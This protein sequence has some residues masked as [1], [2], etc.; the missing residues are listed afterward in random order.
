M[1]PL[2]SNIISLQQAH[3]N[4]D[5]E[6]R[7]FENR[8]GW[9]RQWGSC[10]PVKSTMAHDGPL[11]SDGLFETFDHTDPVVCVDGLSP[12]EKLKVHDAGCVEEQ[13]CHGLPDWPVVQSFLRACPP[14]A[15]IPLCWLWP[16]GQ[17]QRTRT[18]LWLWSSQAGPCFLSVS[19]DFVGTTL[20]S[21]IFV[22]QSE[23]G[24]QILGW[25]WTSWSLWMLECGR[26]DQ[27]LISSRVRWWSCARRAWI[28]AAYCSQCLGLPGLGL[29]LV[30]VRMSPTLKH[31]NHSCTWVLDKVYWP[32][33]PLRALHISIGFLPDFCRNFMVALC[34]NTWPKEW[35]P[36]IQ[37][38]RTTTKTCLTA[39][40]LLLPHMHCTFRQSAK[41]NPQPTFTQR[42]LGLTKKSTKVTQTKSQKS[43]WFP[44]HPKPEKNRRAVRFP[45]CVFWTRCWIVSS[46]SNFK[47]PK[48]WATQV[49]QIQASRGKTCK[50][51]C[52]GSKLFQI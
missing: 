25:L 3:L 18:C 43:P 31:P 16:Q 9:S 50:Q 33:T 46:C 23:F 34:S 30:V 21:G 40:M 32:Y 35:R 19:P 41:R 14:W 38:Q 29:S 28:W 2:W 13:D 48:W 4:R 51:H 5:A 7:S 26:P 1:W 24:A 17:T 10:F 22:P 8:P 42:S 45:S 52:L 47:L 27:V 39:V 11:A 12:G 44:S 15:S 37:L 20:H 49:N 36:W 6:I